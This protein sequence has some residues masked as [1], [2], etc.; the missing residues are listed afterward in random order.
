MNMFY[1]FKVFCLH[2]SD[3]YSKLY[4]KVKKNFSQKVNDD[5]K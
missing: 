1:A 3:H 2:V 4:K 5:F